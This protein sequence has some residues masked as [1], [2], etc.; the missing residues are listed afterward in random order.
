MLVRLILFAVLAAGVWFAVR[1]FLGPKR[2]RVP[3]LWRSVARRHA[4]VADAI[5]LRTSMATAL[6]PAPDARALPILAEVDAVIAGIVKLA[7]T[8]EAQGL[9]TDETARHAVAELRTLEAQLRAEVAEETEARLDAVRGRI[10]D[11]T[12]DLRQTIAARREID[13]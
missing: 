12:E 11:R 5:A 10:A 7:Q 6:L 4:E 8:R 9:P 13:V 2:L 3:L 1:A